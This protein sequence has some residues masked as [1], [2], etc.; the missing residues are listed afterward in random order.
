VKKLNQ[1]QSFWKPLIFFICLSPF[2]LILS[3]TFGLFGNLGVN[4]VETLLDYFGNWALRFII[5]ALSITPIRQITKWNSVSRFR[6]MIGL[7]A[8]FYALMHF[9]IWVTLEKEFR[10]NKIL[11][12]FFERPFIALGFM[13]LFLLTALA[14]TSFIKIRLYMKEYWQPLHNM[15][16]VIG[17]LS[18]WHYWWQ[19]KKDITEPIIYA[20]ILTFLLIIR[21][22]YKRRN[23]N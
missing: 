3:N 16:Y 19:V 12:D 17:I 15:V 9:F 8:F 20:T 1:I 23:V 14:L 2:L 18:I 21:I 4:Q 5:I 7:F 13:S 22:I 10:L 11:E 6:R